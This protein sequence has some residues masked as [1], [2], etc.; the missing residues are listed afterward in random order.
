[1]SDIE[2]TCATCV[3]AST[4][5]GE[6][7]CKRYPQAIETCE[8]DWCGEWAAEPEGVEEGD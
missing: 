6:M 5:Y 7:V 8:A 2:I 3:Y 4:G 1:M